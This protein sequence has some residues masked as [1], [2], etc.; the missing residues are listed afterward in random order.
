MW[1]GRPFFVAEKP[2]Y[3]PPGSKNM[4]KNLALSGALLLMTIIPANAANAG[5][6]D[7]ISQDNDSNYLDSSNWSLDKVLKGLQLTEEEEKLDEKIEKEIVT[8]AKAKSAVKSR[9]T[10]SIA[11]K[12]TMTVVATAYSST[13]DQTDSTPFTTAWNTTVRD[14][15]VAANFLPFGTEIRIPEVFGNK[16]FVVEDRMNKRYQYRIDVWFPERELA[17]EFGV[18]KVIIEVI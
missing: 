17:R 1:L 5:F 8:S 13:P 3:I 9:A 7:W 6:L 14:G 10:K 12:K 18:K 2:L 15:I 4:F 16:I 11:V